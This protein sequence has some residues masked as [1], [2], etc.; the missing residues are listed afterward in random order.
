MTGSDRQGRQVRPNPPRVR[1]ARSDEPSWRNPFPDTMLDLRPLD[2]VRSLKGKLIVIIA[3]TVTMYA[4]ITWLGDRLADLGVL[5]MFPLA[6][7]CSLVVT[8]LLAR[9]MTR[10]LREM[11]AAA[12]AM[13]RGDYSIRVDTNSKDEVGQLAA[14]FNSMAGDLDALDSQRRE[15]VANVSHELRTPVAALRA[16][17]ENMADGVIEPDS[18]ALEA[19]LAQIER[20]SRLIAYLLDLS[21]LE[22]GATDLQVAPIAVDPFLRGITDDASRASARGDLHWAV[23]TKPADLRLVGDEERLR[24]VVSN[25]LDNASRHS[26]RGGTVTVRTSATH[27]YVVI[28][29]IDEGHGIP[30]AERDQVF[31][32]FQRGNAPTQTGGTSTGGTG[33]GLA[34]ARWAVGLHEGTIAV[35]DPPGGVGTRI[36]V[37]LPAHGPR[38]RPGEDDDAVTGGL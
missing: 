24:Q 3:A 13:A 9:G 11:T 22:A 31:G 10:P 19:A 1:H 25:L 34:I 7:V 14:A 5:R 27:G 32:R 20:L 37:R 18:E 23:E 6:L 28:D 15:M 33:L 4:L 26:P 12:R 36:R 17:V 16:Q 21:R 29:V 38:A 35:I 2:P 8:Q 30:E